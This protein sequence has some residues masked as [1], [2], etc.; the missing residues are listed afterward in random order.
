MEALLA[1]PEV[2]HQVRLLKPQIF[3]EQRILT[4]LQQKF[5]TKL[6]PYDYE[7]QYRKEKENVAVDALS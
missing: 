3:M 2:H 1:W 7:V 6:L 5:I 4:P